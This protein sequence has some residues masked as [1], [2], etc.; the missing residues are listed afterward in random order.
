MAEQKKLQGRVALVTGA[1]KRLGRAIALR[2]AQ[3]GADVAIHYG[4]SASDARD[5]VE[6]IEK[7]GRR[8]VAIPAEL[9]DVAAIPRLVNEV[10]EQFG[11]LDILINTAATFLQT[12]FG[13]T[14]EAIWHGSLDTNLKAP[15]FLC[16]AAAPYLAKSGHGVI[17]NFADL[18]GLLGWRDFLPHSLSKAGIVMLTRILAK[19]LAP[20]VRVNAIAPGTITMP[21]D[22]PEWQADYIRLAPLGRS[23]RPDEITDAVLYLITAE[24][25]TGHVLVLDGGRS[26]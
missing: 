8:A 7:F 13:E 23:G 3:E 4:K 17:I 10:I 2:L 19:E 6:Q 25:I 1:G 16:Q 12:K 22:P 5:V 24:F 14:T 11:Q 18:G 21:G 9:T 15:F 20:A 26:L